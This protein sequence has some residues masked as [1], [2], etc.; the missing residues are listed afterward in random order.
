MKATRLTLTVVL[1]IALCS[2]CLLSLRLAPAVRAGDAAREGPVVQRNFDLFIIAVR[3]SDG[4]QEIAS[5]T[6]D[7]MP[8]ERRVDLSGLPLPDPVAVRVTH[9]GDTAAHIDEIALGG[10]APRTVEGTSE[11]AALALK[12]LAQRD[13]DVV[14]AEGRSIHLTFDRSSDMSLSLIA[15]MEPEDIP[16]TPFRFPPQDQQGATES[17]DSFYTYVLG[18]RPGALSIDGDL[19]DERLGEPFFQVFCE[20]TTGHPDND[21]FGW[22]LN[23]ERYLYVAMDFAADN[24]MDGDKDFAAVYVRTPTGVRRFEVSV[25]HQTYGSPGFSYTGAA[26]YQHK[27]YEFRIPLRELGMDPVAGQPISVAF[28]A[29]GTASQDVA[30]SKSNSVGGTATPGV[31]FTWTITLGSA[32]EFSG[33]YFGAGDTVLS[34]SLPTGDGIT[35]G[36]VSVISRS[37]SSTPSTL[38]DALICAIDAENVLVCSVAI[39]PNYNVYLHPGVTEALDVS[40]P[41]TVSNPGTYVN[42][43]V[44]QG[45]MANPERLPEGQGYENN[46]CSDT[47]TVGYEE[48]PVGGFTSPSGIAWATWYGPLAL[49]IALL[50]L[51]AAG[52]LMVRRNRS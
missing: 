6:Y 51:F 23:D 50:W 44:P 7:K 20:P 37:V 52:A 39:G 15:R 46:Y 26:A 5:L 17:L 13:H 43:R 29:Y 30:A 27:V 28:E 24:T 38:S 31:P 34:D 10:E 4:W 36:P 32:Y 2:V 3:T 40:F 8:T 49:A 19:T 48:A 35:Y 14:D 33:Y 25:P 45:C 42:P 22:V 12:K 41:V 1:G 47:V 9:L 11:D 21:T 16:K 18:S